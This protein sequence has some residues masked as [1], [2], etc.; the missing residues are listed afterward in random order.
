[1]VETKAKFDN[2]KINIKVN[3]SL[4]CYKTYNYKVQNIKTTP[5]FVRYGNQT[6]G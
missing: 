1:M 5:K 4:I 6:R 3:N 2:F